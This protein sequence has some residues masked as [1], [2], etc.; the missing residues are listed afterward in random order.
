[1][2]AF[3]AAYTAPL[4]DRKYIF[5]RV[6]RAYLL[7]LGFIFLTC[8]LCKTVLYWDREL[9]KADHLVVY[10]AFEHFGLKKNLTDFPLCCSEHSLPP[11]DVGIKIVNSTSDRKLRELGLEGIIP[12]QFLTQEFLNTVYKYSTH[13]SS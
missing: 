12:S 1:M 8:I 11:S 6:T 7:Q 9:I 4:Y 3:D 2:L 13:T 10:S 5:I